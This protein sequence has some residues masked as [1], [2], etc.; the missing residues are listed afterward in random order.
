VNRSEHRVLDGS[1]GAF[2][3]E[4]IALIRSHYILLLAGPIVIALAT[5]AISS[6]LPDKYTSISY[7]RMNRE[8]S[9]SFMT[10]TISPAIVDKVLARY[11]E[12]GTSTESRIRYL[13][14]RIAL[15]DTEPLLA[16]REVARIFIFE[17]TAN[18]AREAQQI[19]SDLIDAWL[20]TNP[21]LQTE[22]SFLEGELNRNR[23]TADAGLA[24]IDRLQKD[25][26]SPLTPAMAKLN[27]SLIR[28][29]DQSLALVDAMQKRLA[30]VTREAIVAP[31]NLPQEPA[32][33]RKGLAI[34]AGL[35]S[36][37]V[38]LALLA[39]ARLLSRG[40][41]LDPRLT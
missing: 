31:P 39:C 16:D 22:R 7:L 41:R 19:N 20:E 17:I 38:I 36:I 9:R 2:S 15:T 23:V 11:P 18:D 33:A 14:E 25:V 27:S 24:L 6:F 32:R 5:F 34:L 40:D 28:R 3:Q 8:M 29:L 12:A 35:L 13:T 21:L 37:P 30:G 10:M 26:S 1:E 4:L